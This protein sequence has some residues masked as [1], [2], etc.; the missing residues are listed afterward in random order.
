MV[1]GIRFEIQGSELSNLMLAKAKRLEA[2]AAKIFED[3]LPRAKAQPK[4]EEEPTY[5]GIS[6]FGRSDPVRS[7]EHTMS[8]CRAEAVKLRFKASK[9]D[10][11]ERYQFKERQF[12]KLQLHSE[13]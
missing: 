5:L 8:V 13:D 1:K 10:P 12:D 11:A 6:L 4:A 7:L 3:D 9:L 2:K